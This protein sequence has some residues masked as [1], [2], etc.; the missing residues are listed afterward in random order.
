MMTGKISQ[1]SSFGIV[2]IKFNDT[3]KTYGINISEINSTNTQ[4]TIL[5]ANQRD[6]ES[7]FNKT[8]LDFTWYV[9]SFSS[10]QI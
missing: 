3:L 2:I 8:D 9:L 7:G 4:I 10:D 1:I 5:A 6:K